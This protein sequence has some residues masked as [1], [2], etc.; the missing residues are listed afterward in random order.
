[1]PWIFVAYFHYRLT[2]TQSP[3]ADLGATGAMLP[4]M[5]R[6]FY[7]HTALRTVLQSNFRTA[8]N[9]KFHWHRKKLFKHLI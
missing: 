2:L 1:M 3:L 4:N 8:K 9:V 5:R 6:P 7:K